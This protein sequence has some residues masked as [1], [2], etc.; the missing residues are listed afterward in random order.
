MTEER[1]KEIA[2]ALIWNQFRWYSQPLVDDGHYRCNDRACHP[3]SFRVVASQT[4]IS[5]AE[6]REFAQP[7]IDEARAIHD[8]ENPWRYVSR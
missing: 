1:K 4:G 7:F 6:L 5:E 3:G 8:A 2:L